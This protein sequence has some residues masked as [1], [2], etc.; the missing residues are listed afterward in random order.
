MNFAIV[1]IPTHLTRVCI[2]LGGFEA[3]GF[4]VTDLVRNGRLNIY[5]GFDYRQGLKFHWEKMVKDGFK[6]TSNLPT[7]LK[8]IHARTVHYNMLKILKIISEGN[9]DT[10]MIESDVKWRTLDY[11]TLL[12]RWDDLKH[13]VMYRNIHVAML[14]SY[15]NDADQQDQCT[16]I[17]DF[18][19]RGSRNAGQVANIWT[20][21]GAK[22]YLENYLNNHIEYTLKSNPKMEGLYSSLE[23]QVDFTFGACIDAPRRPE[24]LN[25]ILEN[26]LRGIDLCQDLT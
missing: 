16:P 5:N 26:F 21:H 4:P 3:A 22:F 24:K 11:E 1:S 25:R 9:R 19:G 17:D 2:M 15:E 12:E 7:E 6:V 13:Q 23:N 14:F 20:P 8:E 10:L 18:W